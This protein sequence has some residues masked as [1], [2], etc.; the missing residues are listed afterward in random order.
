MTLDDIVRFGQSWT[1]KDLDACMAYFTEDAVFAASTGDGPGKDFVGKAAIRAE[2][3]RI[4]ADPSI[5]P[6]VCGRCWIDA[7][8]GGME[9]SLD[10][11]MG[12]GATRTVRGVDLYEFRGDLI[13]LKDSYRK[14]LA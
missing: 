3:E 6:L 8:R 5:A 4:F 11:R 14:C 10:R 2:L 13:R 1:D 7:D 12:D 9:W